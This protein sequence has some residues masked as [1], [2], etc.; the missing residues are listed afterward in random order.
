M[1]LS[2][3]SLAI[4]RDNFIFL[5]LFGGKIHFWSRTTFFVCCNWIS[6][7]VT[8]KVHLTYYPYNSFPSFQRLFLFAWFW[9]W[10]NAGV[11]AAVAYGLSCSYSYFCSCAFFCVLHQI[12]KKK[13]VVKRYAAEHVTNMYVYLF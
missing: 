10:H 11:T 9:G 2:I 5:I 4:A 8:A 13:E 7:P 6:S 3:F 1:Q 12:L